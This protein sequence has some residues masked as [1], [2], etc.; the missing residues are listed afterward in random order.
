M[1]LWNPIARYHFSKLPPLSQVPRVLN[2]P[3]D[4]FNRYFVAQGAPIVCIGS[5]LLSG[6]P[7]TLDDIIRRDGGKI[8]VNVR[9]GDYS[10]VRTRQEERMTLS[11]YVEQYVR[12]W[13]RDAGD[14][15]DAKSLPRYAGNTPLPR[16]DFEAL[17]FG[18]PECF[19]SK[20]FD[21][22]RLWFG[23]RGSMT[24]LH[25]DSRDN[26][27]CQ[28]MG[29]K[30]LTLYPPSQIPW[31]YT[32]G[33][34]PA[35][36]GVADPRRPDLDQFPLFTR[37]K[38]VEVTLS[39]GEMLYLPARWSHFVLNLDTSLMVNFWPER[40]YAR[41]TLSELKRRLRHAVHAPRSFSPIRPR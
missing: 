16:E 17:G 40:T 36:S 2:P 3:A 31:L 27:I 15:G 34:A 4:V 28:Y 6:Q 23:P 13:E 1:P 7:R 18:Y 35:W 8:H 14:V 41:R 26:L 11:E 38:A 22:P 37:A 20:T 33:H 12:P 29:T 5:P 25:Y 39:A 21:T 10:N 30:H 24:A 9:G 32:R 19:D